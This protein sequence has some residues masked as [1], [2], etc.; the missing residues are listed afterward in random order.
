[1]KVWLSR[2]QNVCDVHMKVWENFDD[3][4]DESQ[5]LE[6]TRYEAYVE[7]KEKTNEQEGN[8]IYAQKNYEKHCRSEKELKAALIP[9][10][11]WLTMLISGN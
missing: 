4:V 7:S 2:F 3:A 9:M 5:S 10:D 6:K 11:D 1:M 8:V